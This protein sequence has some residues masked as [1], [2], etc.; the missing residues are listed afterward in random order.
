MKNKGKKKYII[1][2]VVLLRTLPLGLVL[3]VIDK[4]FDFGFDFISSEGL[5]F[6]LLLTVISFILLGVFIGVLEW[7]FYKKVRE[8]KYNNKQIRRNYAVI[9]GV[10]SWGLSIALSNLITR[11]HSFIEFL[12]TMGIWLIGGYIFGLVTF[13]TIFN[14]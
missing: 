3:L 13:P 2:N 7:K 4:L 9:Y 1:F 6:D 10:I 8:N 11:S 5:M 12:I 14:K